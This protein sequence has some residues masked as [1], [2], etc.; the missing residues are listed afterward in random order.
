VV[1]VMSN[2]LLARL[3]KYVYPFNERRGFICIFCP[4]FSS[5]FSGEKYGHTV[6]F[7]F[8]RQKGKGIELQLRADWMRAISAKNQKESSA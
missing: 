3:P 1:D 4:I 7:F 6:I 2:L 8:Q 5:S